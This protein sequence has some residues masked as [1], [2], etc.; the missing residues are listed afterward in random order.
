[1]REA[2]MSVRKSV[3]QA[4]ID[5]SKIIFISQKDWALLQRLAAVRHVDEEMVIADAISLEQLYIDEVVLRKG[6]MLVEHA[7]GFKKTVISLIDRL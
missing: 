6:R 1:M 7:N 4:E 3:R 2:R 5:G